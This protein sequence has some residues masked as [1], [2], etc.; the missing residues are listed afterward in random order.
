[1][2][3]LVVEYEHKIANALKKGLEQESYVVD[4][5]YDGQTGY[6][7][8]VSEP[9][10]M[11]L[12]DIM[13]PEINGL[14]LCSL[15]RKK[16]INTPIIMLTAKG[17]VRDKVAGLDTGA[18]DYITKPFSFEELLARVRALSR[19][20]SAIIENTL[21][22]GGLTLDP[23]THTVK[24]D[25]RTIHLT[26]KEYGLLEYFMRN[27]ERIL[28]K[29]QITGH[30]WNYDADILPNTVEV[31]IRNLRN[32]IDR[33]FPHKPALIRTVRGFGYTIGA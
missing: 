33:P 11:F 26:P 7:L 30:V 8:A 32:K 5:A 9:Y 15:L 3:I 21:T 6:D 13:L 1:M 18:D 24:R 27:R 12:L 4:T 31:Y 17:Q 20:P 29:E 25:G 22:I 10:D 14:E 28:T 16:H 19:R 23:V 2:R